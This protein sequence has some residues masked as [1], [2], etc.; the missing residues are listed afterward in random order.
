VSVYCDEAGIHWRQEDP[1][2][3]QVRHRDKPAEIWT[4][5]ANRPY[6]S[7]EAIAATR[8]PAG[9][10]EGY[11]EAF[12]NIYGAFAGD[13]RS[14]IASAHPGY[15]TVA[16]GIAAMCFIRAARRSSERGAAWIDLSSAKDHMT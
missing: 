10:P 8:L 5:G 9:H 16:D 13:V 3:L 12:A 7:P 14:G 1:N 11:L 4:A 15:A 6:L 2:T